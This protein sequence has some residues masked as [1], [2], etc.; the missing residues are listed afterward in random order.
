MIEVPLDRLVK[1]ALERLVRPPTE[2]ALDLL[3]IDGVPE[4]VASAID[5]MAD[6]AAM[7]CAVVARAQRIQA[8][9][10][11]LHDGEIAAFAP[12]TDI[13]AFARSSVLQDSEERARDRRRRASHGRFLP[14][15]RWAA[16]VPGARL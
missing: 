13:V 1:P 3:R 10:N 12:T 2:F 11:R 16:S 5:H 14:G 4:I 15:R 6:C 8:V 9:A 7:R